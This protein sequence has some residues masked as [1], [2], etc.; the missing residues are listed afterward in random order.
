M[1]KIIVFLILSQLVF[2]SLMAQ[3]YSQMLSEKRNSLNYG[4]F[5]VVDFKYHHGLFMK[6]SESLNDIMDN[7]YDALDFRVGFQS[8]GK[9]QK[10][11]RLYNFP[12]YGIGFYS[13]AFD[14]GE[15]GT[16][17]ALYMFMRSPVVRGKK[18]TW[19]WELAVGLSYGFYKY[20]PTENPDQQVIGSEHN[21]YFNVATGLSYEL[22]RRFHAKL[23][24]DLTHF[25]NGSTRTPN[26][27]INLAGIA[28]GGRYS[29]NPVKN[30]TKKSDINFNPATRP[31]YE[32]KTIEKYQRHSELI[33]FGSA[34]G[35]TT[36]T[37]IYD[38]PTYFISSLS[39]DY[40]WA[41]HHVG[42]VG[43]GLD[44]FYESA[45]RDYPAKIENA[46]FGDLAYS[47]WH[48]SHYLRMYRLTL[49]TQVGF[50]L[51][52]NVSHKGNRYMQVG[53]SFHIT[54]NLFARA[55]LKTRN[56]AVAD[57]IEWGLGYQIPFGYSKK[58]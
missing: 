19:N 30:Y 14:G 54:D 9:K 28:L 15:L 33:I 3:D 37:Q 23:D 55:A 53:G 38:G 41:Y 8:S 7:P 25:S 12:V 11:D 47:G 4:Y 10:W 56:G 1:K 21:V 13:V 46:G 2:G 36:T 51:T 20:D 35:K 22:N 45:L 16:P 31:Q 57:F 18:L 58:R 49:V 48:V 17:Q 6:N 52:N 50:Y 44:G 26:L 24:F 29:F 32:R 5:N 42:M 40:A 39:I 34:G 43:V 27:G